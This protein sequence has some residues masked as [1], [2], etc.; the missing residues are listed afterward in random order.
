MKRAVSAESISSTT[1]AREGRDYTLAPNE[2][3]TPSGG[4][5]ASI[6]RSSVIVN[7]LSRSVD[8]EISRPVLSF[9][10]VFNVPECVSSPDR[11]IENYWENITTGIQCSETEMAQF[12]LNA[13]QKG[14]RQALVQDIICEQRDGNYSPTL[15]R[16]QERLQY[17]KYSPYK[18]GLVFFSRHRRSGWKH[19]HAYPSWCAC[20]IIR[21]QYSLS[22]RRRVTFTNKLQSTD[23]ENILK[24]NTQKGR[25]VLYLGIEGTEWKYRWTRKF[26]RRNCG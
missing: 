4:G 24:Y 25:S 10:G 13:L 20:A 22:G 21:N 2:E 26:S 12:V 1:T 8:N 14:G 9:H 6:T 16:L 3:E 18:H 19:A 15:A 5:D 11:K 7:G 17:E 23:I